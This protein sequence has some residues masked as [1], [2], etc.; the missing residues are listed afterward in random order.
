MK[1]IIILI[2]SLLIL[3][4]G[5]QQNL[6]EVCADQDF[7]FANQVWTNDK[8]D[9]FVNTSPKNKLQNPLYESLFKK[10]EKD[11]NTNPDTFKAKWK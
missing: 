2:L 5:Q 3:S 9:Q 6:L 7:K 1:L 8:K 4:C 11:R 10:C